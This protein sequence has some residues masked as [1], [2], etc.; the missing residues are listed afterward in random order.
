MWLRGGAYPNRIYAHRTAFDDREVDEIEIGQRVYFRVRFNR[1]GPV[2]VEVHL[3]QSS[4]W[5]TRSMASHPYADA[6]V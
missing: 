4:E 6:I 2:A 5:R 1:V 3:K